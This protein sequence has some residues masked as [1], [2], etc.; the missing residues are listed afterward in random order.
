M[1]SQ[2]LILT[3]CAHRD[4]MPCSLVGGNVS[5]EPTVFT[6]PEDTGSRFLQTLWHYVSVLPVF[7][8]PPALL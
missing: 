2:Q 3:S 5:K 6:Y 8:C 1:F 4:V 7:L